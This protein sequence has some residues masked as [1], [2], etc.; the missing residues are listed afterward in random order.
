[1]KLAYTLA[2]LA[3]TAT[4]GGLGM[5]SP[6]Q[7]Q[8][9]PQGRYCLHTQHSGI[10]SCG[11]MHRQQCVIDAQPMDGWCV[12]TRSAAYKPEHFAQSMADRT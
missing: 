4:V 8:P 1:M 9:V 10:E 3:F 7:A 5:T 6:A 2:A 11:Y 12:L